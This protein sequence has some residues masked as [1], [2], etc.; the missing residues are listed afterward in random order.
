MR[1]AALALLLA[2]TPAAAATDL[3]SA[4]DLAG[5]PV[6]T[7]P[8]PSTGG[9]GVMI[10]GYRPVVEGDRCRTD[11]TA[12]LPDGAVH[13]NTVVFTAVPHA[14]GTLCVDGRWRA[15]DGDAA[16]TT[17]LRVFL[18]DGVARRSP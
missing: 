1:R 5:W 8:F 17:P 6:V 7:D 11:F 16:G 10:G 12:I 2:A 9:G 4:A 13:R 18:K 15:L 3:P 14:G